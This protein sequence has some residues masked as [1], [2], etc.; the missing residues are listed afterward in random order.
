MPVSHDDGAFGYFLMT[1]LVF[2][3]VPATFFWVR[4][5]ASIT[6]CKPRVEDEVS[7]TSAQ[8]SISKLTSVLALQA[9]TSAEQEKVS[10]RLQKQTK[11]STLATPG[12]ILMSIFLFTSYIGMYYAYGN[13]MNNAAIK[14]WNPYEVSVQ[15]GALPSH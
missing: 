13:I 10:R 12:F 7:T 6:C 9:R 11:F 2:Y 1:L 3:A 4:R 15:L 8:Y 5:V 14:Q